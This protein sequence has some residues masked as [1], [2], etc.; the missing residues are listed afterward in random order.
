MG[1]PYIDQYLPPFPLLEEGYVTS[2]K[3]GAHETNILHSCKDP[4]YTA[5]SVR[6]EKQDWDGMENDALVVWRWLPGY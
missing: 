2:P 1:L 3:L 4:N 6:E 5:G